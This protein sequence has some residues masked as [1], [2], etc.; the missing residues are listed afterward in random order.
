M[1]FSFA[2]LVRRGLGGAAE[3][4]GAAARR[5]GAYI[6]DRLMDLSQGGE[7]RICLPLGVLGCEMDE[8]VMYDD[9]VVRETGGSAAEVVVKGKTSAKQFSTLYSL[10][11]KRENAKC[12]TQHSSMM[13]QSWFPLCHIIDIS[14]RTSISLTSSQHTESWYGKRCRLQQEYQTSCTQTKNHLY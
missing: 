4:E 14:R 8:M 11:N 9:E 13:L 2:S 3:V 6:V 10:D 1:L 5:F 7:R 12:T